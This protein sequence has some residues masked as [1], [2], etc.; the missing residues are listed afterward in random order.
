[1]IDEE[2]RRLDR[3]VQNLLDMTRLG[4]GKLK[5]NRDWVDLHDI[6]ASASSRLADRLSKLHLE[7][8]ISAGFPLLWLHGAL[9]EQ[10][11]FNLLDNAIR[12][13]PQSGH[14]RI[15]AREESGNAV[16]EVCDEGPGVP[17][18]EREKIFDMF[19]TAVQGDRSQRQGTGLGLAIC[20]GMIA[21]HG[22][23]IAAE[24][25]LSD[26]GTCMRITLPI[27]TLDNS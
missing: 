18:N 26:K 11:F 14:I 10:A 22:G 1:M 13:S 19:Y 20:R 24:N 7:V 2:A 8:E 12:Y 15:K 21:A 9:I 6:V 23:S 3:H 4:H 17:V 27:N 25:G 5:L 16:I